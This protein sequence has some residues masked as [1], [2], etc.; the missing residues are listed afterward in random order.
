MVTNTQMPSSLRQIKKIKDCRDGEEHMVVSQARPSQECYV[1]W[2]LIVTVSV[3]T[4]A[5]C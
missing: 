1:Q 4:S 5:I 3:I 2:R